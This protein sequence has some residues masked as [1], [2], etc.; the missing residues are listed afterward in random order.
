MPLPE[1]G[2]PPLQGALQDRDP[3]ENK[4]ELATAVVTGALSSKSSRAGRALVRRGVPWG[5]RHFWKLSQGKL[6]TEG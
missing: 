4:S 2:W 1:C 3:T 5:H 6:D